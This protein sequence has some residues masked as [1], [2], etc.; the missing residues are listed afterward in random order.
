MRVYCVARKYKIAGLEKLAKSTIES[1]EGEISVFE[2]LDIAK[3]AYQALPHDET[4][5]GVY[6]KK[7]VKTAFEADESFIYKKAL[8]GSHRG[9]EEL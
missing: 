5:F 9:G 4:W 8:L 7:M 3:E 1:F 6:L 2:F